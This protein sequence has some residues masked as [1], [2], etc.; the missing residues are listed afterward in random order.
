ME[1]K[2]ISEYQ[3]YNSE[4]GYNLKLGGE[5]GGLCQES[6]RLKISLSSKQ[7]W[8]NPELAEKMSAGL[9]KGT[10]TIKR[11]AK[12]NYIE[13]TCVICG[14]LM[15]QKPYEHIN[16][17]C[18]KECVIELQKLHNPGLEAANKRNKENL[19]KRQEE[20]RNIAID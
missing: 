16:K 15:K 11:R 7:N 17:C 19:E 20:I 2:Y 9:K 5:N 12:E 1:I 10:E 13:T 3:A 6:T 4:F 14:K 8:K 18:S